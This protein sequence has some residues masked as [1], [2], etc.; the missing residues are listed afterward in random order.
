MSKA[1]YKVEDRGS[2][3]FCEGT[4]ELPDFRVVLYVDGEWIHEW[5]GF[6]T[7]QQATEKANLMNKQLIYHSHWYTVAI[8]K[9]TKPI[10]VTQDET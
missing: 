2:S 6:W 3:F 4:I 10:E 8:I 5:E 1:I 9:P 7:E